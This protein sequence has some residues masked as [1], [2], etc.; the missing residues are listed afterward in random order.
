LEKGDW[1]KDL[2]LNRLSNGLTETHC[3]LFRIH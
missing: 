2:I 3:P 1:W